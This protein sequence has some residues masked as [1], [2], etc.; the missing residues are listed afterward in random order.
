MALKDFALQSFGRIDV[1]VNNAGVMPTSFLEN[2]ATDEWD[3]LIDIN[4]KGVLYC[5]GA[6]LHQMR[7]QKSG[8]IVNVSS[9]AAYDTI[10][11][12]STVYSMTK[13]AVQEHIGRVAG[14]GGNERLQYPCDRDLPRLH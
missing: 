11:P 7:E 9:N 1:L 2:N 3:R 10:N 14:R 12:Y 5:I 6:V 8:H 4:I 13:H